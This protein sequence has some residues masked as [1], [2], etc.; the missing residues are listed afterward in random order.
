MCAIETFAMSNQQRQNRGLL[1]GIVVMVL[2]LVAG[3]QAL[4]ADWPQFRGPDHNG[5]STETDFPLSWGVGKNIRWR[6]SLPQPANSSPIVSAG[7]VFITCTQDEHGLRRT[8]Y[9]FD[10]ADGTKRWERTVAYDRIDPTHQRNPYCASTPA[11]DGQR[12]VAWH[13]SA[14]VHCYDFEGK[15][16]WSRDLGVFRHIW[17]YASSPIIYGDSIILNC[18]PGARSFVIALD[19]KTGRT[20]WQ[21]DQP[22]GADDRGPDGK[23]VG[24]WAT[25]IIVKVDGRDQILVAQSRHVNSYEPNS[26]HILWTCGGTGDLAYADVMAGD[27][28]AVAASGYGGPAVGFKL[29]GSGDVSD[30]RLWRADRNPQ[31]IGTGVVIGPNLFM[32]NEPGLSCIELSSGRELWKQRLAGQTFWGSIVRAGDRLY[33]TS[34][35]GTTYVYAADSKAFHLLATNDLAEPTNSTPALANGHVFLR[36]ASALYCVGEPR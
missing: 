4:A 36:T 24:S 7:N 17:G 14:G 5:V 25:P 22:G 21:T 29:G 13:G 8:L 15:E 26:G 27:G 19:R 20:L 2:L 32:V 16:L 9:C 6:A 23:W 10:A 31:R 12:V 11:A 28:T 18:G 35:Q 1:A 34:Q 3:I 30:N 33:V